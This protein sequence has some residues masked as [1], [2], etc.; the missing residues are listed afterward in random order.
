VY[1]HVNNCG[2]SHTNIGKNEVDWMAMK[3]K[4][5]AIRING[6]MKNSRLCCIVWL[7][8][9]VCAVVI[10]LQ[11]KRGLDMQHDGMDSSRLGDRLRGVDVLHCTSV[12][13]VLTSKLRSI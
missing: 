1:V 13:V 12:N 10:V 8:L 3:W 6:F 11:Y 2:I 4:R 7:S 5:R 9:T